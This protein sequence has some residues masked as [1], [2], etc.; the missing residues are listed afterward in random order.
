MSIFQSNDVP[1]SILRL[2]RSRPMP[3]TVNEE[4]SSSKGRC[5][6]PDGAGAYPAYN[7]TAR[8]R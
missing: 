3:E 7:S 4:K 6:M 1:P 2:G 5:K 8:G